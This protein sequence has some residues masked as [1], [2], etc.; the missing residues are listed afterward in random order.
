MGQVFW[1]TFFS[2]IVA[3]LA[4]FAIREVPLRGHAAAGDETVPE[5]LEDVSRETAEIGVAQ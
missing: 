2:A 5:I 4:V 3:L 1:L